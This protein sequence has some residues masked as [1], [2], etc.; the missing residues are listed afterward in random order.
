MIGSQA[1]M[2][3]TRHDPLGAPGGHSTIRAALALIVVTL[4]IAIASASGQTAASEDPETTFKSIVDLLDRAGAAGDN[5]EQIKL[6]EQV[7]VGAQAMKEWPRTMPREVWLGLIRH[8]LG[9]HYMTRTTGEPADNI[10][11]AIALFETVQQVVDLRR[12]RRT[13]IENHDELGRA[14]MRRVRGDRQENLKKASEALDP[15]AS[16]LDRK[17]RPEAWA[18]VMSNLGYVYSQL[19]LGDREHNIDMAMAD[20]AAADTV[21]TK[22]KYPDAWA[23]NQ[24]NLSEALSDRTTGGRV[25]NLQMA[26]AANAAAETI[27]VRGTDRRWA[28]S[29]LAR[30]KALLA[31]AE[32]QGD[33]AEATRT[34]LSGIAALEAARERIRRE[35]YQR[36]WAILRFALA[37]A[38]RKHVTDSASDA[39]RAIENY[40]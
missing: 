15:V 9:K 35:E 19:E 11:R 33:T 20:L 17:R 7:I 23:V 25:N 28:L 39:H 32:Q 16:V 34:V 26:I 38:Y 21:F 10:D 22:E 24:S 5:D 36:E 12:D 18:A 30:G 27:F 8:S 37:S 1:M 4:L 13:W 2:S 3:S 40:Q 6:L 31:L 14:Y 29:E